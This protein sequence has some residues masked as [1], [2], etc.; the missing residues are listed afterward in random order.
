M[1]RLE[2]LRPRRLLG[3]AACAALSLALAGCF[4]SGGTSSPSSKDP[5]AAV[6][7]SALLYVEAYVRPTGAMLSGIDAA[8]NE[9]L[10]IADPGATID[11]AIDGALP[12]GSSYEHDIRPWLGHQAAF[13]LLGGTTAASARVAVVIDQTNATLAG[14]LLAKRAKSTGSDGGVTYYREGSDGYAA[15]V[16]SFLVIANDLPALSAIIAVDNGAAAL[17]GDA[18]FKQDVAAE[19]P[20][21][22][23]FAYVSAGQLLRLFAGLAAHQSGGAALSLLLQPFIRKYASLKVYG[24]ARLNASGALVDISTSGAPAGGSSGAPSA[25]TSA[26]PIGTLPGGSW[27]ALGATDVGPALAGALTTLGQIGGATSGGATSFAQ[28][29]K[30]IQT[31][32]GVNVEADLRSITTLGVFVKGTTLA[33]LEAGVVLGVDDPA[34]AP[35]LVEQIRRL[36]A[37]V[38]SSGHA[39]AIGSLS[40]SGVQAGFT[41]RVPGVPYAFAVAAANGEIV[42]ALDARSLADA[43][44]SG[45]RLGSGASYASATALLGGGIQPDLIVDLPALLTFAESAGGFE[46]SSA[47]QLLTHLRRLGVLALGTGQQDGAEHLRIALGPS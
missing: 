26:N 14:R 45:G 17:A 22:A 25:A 9:L 16:G 1:N 20:G 10:G 32:T 39:F 30:A 42:V 37:L 7:A 19:L 43:I 31:A 15:V 18:S 33:S 12:P 41:L 36:L 29:L 3:L 27:L 44:A 34:R 46:G 11:A 6:P 28:D 35:A 5:A 8:S 13:A 4:G 47:Q 40:A 23:G 38:A 2:G 21:A 24:S